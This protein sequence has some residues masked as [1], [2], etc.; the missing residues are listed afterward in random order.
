MLYTKWNMEDAL[1]TRYKEGFEVGFV[2]GIMERNHETP[3]NIAR[4]L[5]IMGLSTG[6]VQKRTGVDME[7]LMQLTDNKWFLSSDCISAVML[8]MERETE[9]VRKENM[10]NIVRNLLAEGSTPEFVQKITG[11][12]METIE[13]LRAGQ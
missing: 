10:A 12:D 2:M 7:I 1:A 5:L 11:L 3:L 9:K 6:D 8:D 4:K 13:G